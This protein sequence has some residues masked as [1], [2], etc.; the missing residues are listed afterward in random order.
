MDEQRQW[1]RIRRDPALVR[2]FLEG[3]DPA[4]IR[5]ALAEIPVAERLEGL[6]PEQRPQGLSAQERAVLLRQLQAGADNVESG[7]G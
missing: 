7:P 4:V 1:H 3:H 5:Q 6:T 2:V